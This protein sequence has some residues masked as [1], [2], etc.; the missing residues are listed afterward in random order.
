M[1]TCYKKINSPG[2]T[3]RKGRAQSHCR[4][5]HPSDEKNHFVLQE[6]LQHI[7][8]EFLKHSF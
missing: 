8:S 3:V 6:N 2:L 1:Q 7:T 5:R 4:E